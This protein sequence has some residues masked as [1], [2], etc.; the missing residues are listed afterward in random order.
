MVHVNL[1]DVAQVGF[2]RRACDRLQAGDDLR[3]AALVARPLFGLGPFS[4]D[5]SRRPRGDLIRHPLAAR[6]RSGVLADQRPY[7][8]DERTAAQMHF[9]GDSVA[10]CSTP[11]AVP[12]VLAGQDR[13]PVDAAT[14][15]AWAYQFMA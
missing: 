10:A 6:R 2:A 1:A 15:G 8:V 11:A 14:D 3:R 4:L 9:R 7:R 5:F 12:E 13:E